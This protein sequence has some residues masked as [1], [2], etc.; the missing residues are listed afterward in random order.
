MAKDRRGARLSANACGIASSLSHTAMSLVPRLR[1]GY[2]SGGRDT[3]NSLGDRQSPRGARSP[4]LSRFRRYSVPSP[5]RSRF[6]TT[7]SRDVLCL[8]SASSSC[9]AASR[10]RSRWDQI[11]LL[12]PFRYRGRS[13][14]EK[15]APITSGLLRGCCNASG[16]SAPLNLSA[17]FPAEEARVRAARDTGEPEGKV[18]SPAQSAPRVPSTR[19]TGFS[20]SSHLA[21]PS[22]PSS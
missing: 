12:Q 2:A 9:V 14:T 5:H 13:T 17:C 7:A 22:S 3:A 15:P 16:I 10:L 1:Q 19:G 11:R 21:T 6:A 18:K 8:G 20:S 4:R